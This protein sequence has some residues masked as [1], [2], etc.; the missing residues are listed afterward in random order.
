M[1]SSG[2]GPSCFRAAKPLDAVDVELTV[3]QHVNVRWGCGRKMIGIDL[4]AGG[5][6]MSLGATWAGIDVRIA[7]ELHPVACQTYRRN[8][9]NTIVLNQDIRTVSQLKVVRRDDEVVVFGGPPCQGFSTSNQRTRD[10]SNTRN[11]LFLEFLR[12]VGEIGPEWVVFENVAGILQTEKGYFARSLKHRLRT[13]GYRV[14]DGLLNARE[15]GI[16]QRRARYFVIGARDRSPPALDPPTPRSFV[17][18][19]DAIGDLPFLEN[20]AD[21]D[22]LPY[23]TSPVS[24][25]A[26]RLR[27]NRTKCS[28][29]LVTH[30]ADAIIKRYPH[31]PQGGNWGDIPHELMDTYA[32]PKRCHTGIYRRLSASEPAVVIGNF[33][34]NMLIHPTQDRGLSVREAARLQSFPDRYEFVGSIGLQQQQVGNAVPPLLARSVFDKIVAVS[35]AQGVTNVGCADPDELAA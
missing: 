19:Q 13:L 35:A 27:G 1:V 3:R 17:T 12:I 16:P 7:I 20:G 24:S 25:Y 23:R 30:N 5:G 21:I 15:A 8:H 4:F 6:G 14:T 2:E 11:W 28:G 29:H 10:R 22:V 34:K 26:K 33:R 18:V 9:A 31:I 32:D